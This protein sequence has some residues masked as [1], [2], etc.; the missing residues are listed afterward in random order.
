MNQNVAWKT[1]RKPFIL[2]CVYWTQCTIIWNRTWRVFGIG[3]SYCMWDERWKG[4]ESYGQLRIRFNFGINNHMSQSWSVWWDYAARWMCPMDIRYH[5]PELK[6]VNHNR[7]GLFYTVF[8][9]SISIPV[10]TFRS[11][12]SHRKMAHQTRNLM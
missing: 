12:C 5:S 6:L 9:Q 2:N 10:C 1:K 7:N 3:R 4:N 11:E 8:A